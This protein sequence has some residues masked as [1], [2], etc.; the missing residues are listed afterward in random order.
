MTLRICSPAASTSLFFQFE[1]LLSW[2]VFE[3]RSCSGL[4]RTVFPNDPSYTYKIMQISYQY[5]TKQH[6]N[7]S[8]GGSTCLYKLPAI[9]ISKQ[10]SSF[11]SYTGCLR[12]E[13]CRCWLVWKW[14]KNLHLSVPDFVNVPFYITGSLHF[15]SLIYQISKLNLS[16]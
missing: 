6:I 8:V 16:L 10:L 1:I 7:V 9:P 15:I 3:S 12:I 4:K 13:Y 14:I 5:S 11:L 2:C